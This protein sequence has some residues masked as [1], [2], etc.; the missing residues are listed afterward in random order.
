MELA[1]SQAN[2]GILREQLLRGIDEAR[3]KG[4]GDEISRLG[5]SSEVR[6]RKKRGR[7]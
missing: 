5:K 2:D 6:R 4:M 3:K 1:E 7:D